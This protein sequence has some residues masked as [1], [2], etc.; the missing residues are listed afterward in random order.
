MLAL[1]GVGLA[2]RPSSLRT[3]SRPLK[4]LTPV[5]FSVFAAFADRVTPGGAGWPSAAD[6]QVAEKIDD[7]LA[8]CEPGMVAEV[9]QAASLLENA[10][11]GLL[12][13]GRFTTFTACTAQQQDEIIESWRT[14]SLH[15]RRTVYKALRG[16]CA[17]A[18]FASPQTWT[19]VGY[20]GPPRFDIPPAAPPEVTP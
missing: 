6:M 5:T 16:L 11:T 3:P 13:D 15:V 2:L 7:L 4:A 12:L 20:G 9:Q 17:S 14:S 1:G 19:K 10:L 8:T 18:Y